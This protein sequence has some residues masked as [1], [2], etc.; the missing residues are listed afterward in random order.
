MRPTVSSRL[1]DII[2][3]IANQQLQASSLVTKTISLALISIAL[4][5]PN[6]TI[7][8][9]REALSIGSMGTPSAIYVALAMVQQMPDQ[10]DKA[11]ISKQRRNELC[12]EIKSLLPSILQL[13]SHALTGGGPGGLIEMHG[14][15]A[16]ETIAS[17]IKGTG[18]ALSVFA[19]SSEQ[20]GA[21]FGQMLQ[22]LTGQN[23]P[24]AAAAA[25]AL[26]SALIRAE[27]DSEGRNA[28]INALCDALLATQPLLAATADSIT[29]G[30]DIDRAQSTT[31]AIACLFIMFASREL[32]RL[33]GLN[34]AS[35]RN[36]KFMEL[37][38][39]LSAHP[40]RRITLLTQ[41]S[42][43]PIHLLISAFRVSY[44]L[45][46]IFL[47]RIFGLRYQITD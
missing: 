36:I 7:A 19:T 18:L 42:C 43:V 17:W 23:V 31:H 8:H 39:N 16:L 29:S 35:D 24:M 21:L 40:Y 28:A 11:D 1:M 5:L 44:F 3:T 26:N 2:R 25:K 33:I 4:R 45:H 47:S 6:G 15:S 13:C 34:S 32:P 10:L 38:M 46:L 9:T 20:G 14:E 22:L 30:R 12:A 37:F 41:A 27:E